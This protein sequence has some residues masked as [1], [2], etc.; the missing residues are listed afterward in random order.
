MLP[1]RITKLLQKRE[2]GRC[3]PEELEELHQWFDTLTFREAGIKAALTDDEKRARQLKDRIFSGI[4]SRLTQL[5]DTN[6]VPEV[7]PGSGRTLQWLSAAA[8]VAGLLF[9]AALHY[10]PAP[11]PDPMVTVAT[12][13]TEAI[14][15]QLPDSSVVWVKTGSRIRYDQQLGQGP[16]R[17]LF[18][19]GEAFF[20]I[21]HNPDK[22]FIVHT[23]DI[24]I[25]VLGTSFNV[26]SYDKDPSVETSL[27]TG[28][29]SIS[30][31]KQDAPPLILAPNQRAIYSKTAQTMEVNTLVPAAAP[32]E[33]TAPRVR[34]VFDE[35]PFTAVLDQIEKKFDVKIYIDNREALICPFTADLEKENLAEIINLLKDVNGVTCS[36]YGSEI[37]IEGTICHP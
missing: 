11:T 13:D 10:R 29:V 1:E 3:S 32:K 12:S 2:N 36:L 18:L 15:I 7:V 6:L 37:Y 19:E 28:K 27:L 14:K 31:K 26:R 22:P 5:P 25:R 30:S 21:S 24:D 4:H 8:A 33:L 23:G 20:D 35:E 17:E 9:F 16:Y 34:M